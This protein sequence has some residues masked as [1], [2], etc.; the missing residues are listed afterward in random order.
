[1]DKEINKDQ[2]KSR[3]KAPT[4]K[5]LSFQKSMEKSNAKKIKKND[6]DSSKRFS[7]IE[8]KEDCSKS[9]KGNESRNRKP[10]PKY[11]L[12]LSKLQK[13]VTQSDTEKSQST[14]SLSSKPSK[15][16]KSQSNLKTNDLE[17]KKKNEEKQDDKNLSIPAK[18]ER[19]EKPKEIPIDPL[20]DVV[21]E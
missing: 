2:S 17:S 18:K 9:E 10:N 15:R 12:Y 3:I 19:K 16:V 5:F 7:L 6:E 20:K 14:N 11:E 13:V 8:L 4:E 1:M 21:I